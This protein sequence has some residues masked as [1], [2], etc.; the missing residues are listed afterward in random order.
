MGIH[1]VAAAIAGLGLGMAHV[2]AA[3]ESVLAERRAA[4]QAQRNDPG[5]AAAYGRALLR[6]GRY[7]EAETQLQT[8]AR[9]SRGS[10]EALYDVARVAFAQGDYRAARRACGR[11]TTANRTATLTRVCNARAFLVWNR[12]ARAFEELEAALGAAPDDYEA[13]VALGDAHR[14]RADVAEAEAAYR[15]ATE[16]NPSAAEPHLGLGR[17][18]AAAGRRADALTALRE[19]HARDASWPEVTYELG[20]VLEGAEAEQLLRSAAENR[21]G[22]ADAHVA[23]G[24][25]LLAGGDAAAARDQFQRAVELNREL[26]EA[27]EGL[28]VAELR[29]GNLDAADAALARALELVP[30]SAG[31]ALALAN[32]QR[33]RG[34]HQLAFEQYQR[35][36]DID[37][38]SP[39]AMI[40]ATRLAIA[41]DRDVL[42]SG[43]L[44]R[45]LEAHPNLAVAH[46][47]Y[48]DIAARRGDR[49]AAKEHYERALVGDGP[50]SAAFL[51][52]AIDRMSRPAPRGEQFD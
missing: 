26:A 52:G 21:P 44:D 4:V 38:Q 31:A 6:A 20:R 43:F 30:N 41:L 37:P 27:H 28:G 35:A 34:A 33:V 11:L 46:A 5:A 24:A 51:R 23:L 19:A 49:A 47:L 10:L 3:Q 29:V 15:R 36:A 32:L 18:Y 22:W 14:L 7:R 45:V 39:V 8:A 42:A 16:Q 12:S 48:G 50:K 9:L 40:R 17:L 13:L 2:A 1:L 25:R